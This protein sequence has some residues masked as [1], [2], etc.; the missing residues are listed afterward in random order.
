MGRCS[1]F[2]GGGA[3]DS[4]S[5]DS[6]YYQS[7]TGWGNHAITEN[8][9]WD[10]R[11][12]PD[13]GFTCQHFKARPRRVS[14]N[15][16][17]TTA[18]Q[19][20]PTQA[21]GTS[22]PLTLRSGSGSGGRGRGRAASPGRAGSPLLFLGSDRLCLST[23]SAQQS[24]ST[25]ERNGSARRSASFHFRQSPGCCRSRPIRRRCSERAPPLPPGLLLCQPAGSFLRIWGGPP[26]GRGEVQLCVAS[27]GLCLHMF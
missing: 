11:S 2:G 14:G 1:I 8:N 23:N 13:N 9:T 7:T 12:F 24:E 25:T 4:I 17:Q 10:T 5:Q 6:F 21:P 18:V 22:R 19:E 3:Q 26:S 15:W 20:R 27:C 16:V